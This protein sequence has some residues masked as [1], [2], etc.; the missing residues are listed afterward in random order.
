MRFFAFLL[1]ISFLVFIFWVVGWARN[2]FGSYY[3]EVFV[4]ALFAVLLLTPLFFLFRSYLK[5]LRKQYYEEVNAK[6]QEK[7]NAENE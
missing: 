5:V 2:F 1:A 7:V 6:A 4:I 3:G